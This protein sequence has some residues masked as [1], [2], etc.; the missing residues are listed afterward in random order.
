MKM[1]DSRRT[2]RFDRKREKQI[3]ADLL[4]T[5]TSCKY[6]KNELNKL[7]LFMVKSSGQASVLHSASTD[8]SGDIPK[9]ASPETFRINI[10]PPRCS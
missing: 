8:E 6:H 3:L 5:N 7:Q 2:H 9:A 10:Y 1:S 4:R